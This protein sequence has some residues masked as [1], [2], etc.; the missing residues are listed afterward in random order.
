ME[1]KAVFNRSILPAILTLCL[2]IG[3][4]VAYFNLRPYGNEAGF[5][6]LVKVAGI[7]YFISVAFG[8]LFVFSM[9]YIGGAALRE[10]ILASLV[11][12]FF[13][14]T[15]EVIRITESHPISESL[16]WYFNPLNVWLVTLMVLE[17]GIAT[18][19]ARKILKRRGRE[20]SVVTFGPI[21]TIVCSLV[22][23]IS[24]Y[25]WGKGEN[26]YVIFLSGYRAL[27]GSGV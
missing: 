15:K 10:R 24:V 27:F 1:N 5:Q 18:L 17:M 14:M 4:M 23:V 11:V 25:A 3:S 26:V 21:A 13:W 2:T 16:Y 9:S 19:I 6:T 8:T 22:F 7:A 20:I 12:P